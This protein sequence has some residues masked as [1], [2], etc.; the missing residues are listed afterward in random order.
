MEIAGRLCETPYQYNKLASAA[1][2]TLLICGQ[3]PVAGRTAPR[4]ITL[5]LNLRSSSQGESPMK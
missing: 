3:R 1:A 5:F 2:D 4:A